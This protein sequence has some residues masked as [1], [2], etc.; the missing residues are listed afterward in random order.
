MRKQGGRKEFRVHRHGVRG[1]RRGQR[2]RNVLS[3]IK[4]EVG[5]GEG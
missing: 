5:R 1:R 4:E 3:E 2:K